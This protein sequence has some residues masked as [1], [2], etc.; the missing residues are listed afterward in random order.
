MSTTRIC[1]RVFL[2]LCVR[3]GVLYRCR[4]RFDRRPYWFGAFIDAKGL[5]IRRSAPLLYNRYR[6]DAPSLFCQPSFTSPITPPPQLH[7]FHRVPLPSAITT[8]T[9]AP[10]AY[11]Y[12][13]I[14]SSFVTAYR[15]AVVLPTAPPRQGFPATARFSPL[16]PLPP[17]PLSLSPPPRPMHH[18]P[19]FHSRVVPV[20]RLVGGQLLDEGRSGH[21]SVAE[22]VRC[23]CGFESC[24]HSFGTT[25]HLRLALSASKDQR[26]AM[27]RV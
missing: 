13:A 5:L 23:W 10:A 19:T 26:R 12:I 8:R 16:P 17:L 9:A 15:R 20:Y 24:G 22:V 4:S 7:A 18:H 25:G 27:I 11:H 21:A 14:H 1:F 2:C 3:H 6:E